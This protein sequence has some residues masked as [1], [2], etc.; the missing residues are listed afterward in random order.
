MI[1]IPII[2]VF[3]SLHPLRSA[4]HLL[5][6]LQ[7]THGLGRRRH[8]AGGDREDLQETGSTIK[9]LSNLFCI[10]VIRSSRLLFKCQFKMSTNCQSRT[11]CNWNPSLL[12]GVAS[13][14]WS[15]IAASFVPASA[16]PRST[17]HGWMLC[18]CCCCCCWS[19]GSCGQVPPAIVRGF[20]SKAV[21]V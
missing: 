6:T 20:H 9:K 15:Y 13:L 2:P 17:S 8:A 19:I 1:A 7:N 14:I 18:C 3:S 11:F 4:R 5:Q 12:V 16:C 10:K 21:L